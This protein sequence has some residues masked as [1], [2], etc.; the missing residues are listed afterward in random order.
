MHFYL[1]LLSRFVYFV[2]V[3][4]NLNELIMNVP[5]IRENLAFDVFGR[6]LKR[7]LVNCVCV[8][9]K[10]EAVSFKDELSK[11]EYKISGLCQKCQD[12]VFGSEDE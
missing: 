7:S 12:G 6:S 5:E 3:D 9:C 11:R 2:R 10:Q 4:N 8:C 1:V